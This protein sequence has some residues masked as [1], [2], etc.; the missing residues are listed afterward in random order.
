[1]DIFL[2]LQQPAF[3][4]V[5]TRIWA[6]SRHVWAFGMPAQLPNER[7][8]YCC[9]VLFLQ[10]YISLHQTRQRC[11]SAFGAAQVMKGKQ[12]RS[13][14]FIGEMK[15]TIKSSQRGKKKFGV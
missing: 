5:P 4:R 14:L 8:C 3:L 11:C 12:S 1:M 10:A 15:L 7:N 2:I 9:F 6:Y 13:V